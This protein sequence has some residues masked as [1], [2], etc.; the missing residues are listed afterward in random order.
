MHDFHMTYE[1]RKKKSDVTTCTCQDSGVG[2]RDMYTYEQ[3]VKERTPLS[4]ELDE[5]GDNY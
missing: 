4:G 3:G 5:K 1:Q 2:T